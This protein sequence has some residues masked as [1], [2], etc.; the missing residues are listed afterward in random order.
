MAFNASLK[1]YA[2][3]GPVSSPQTAPPREEKPCDEKPREETQVMK[4]RS[5]VS[6]MVTLERHIAGGRGE[7]GDWP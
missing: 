4:N 2:S 6:G 5:L 1:S 3:L 7:D